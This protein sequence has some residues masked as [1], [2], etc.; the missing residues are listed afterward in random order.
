ML[1]FYKEDFVCD[2]CGPTPPYIIMDGKMTGPKQEL[3]K[4]I[5]ELDRHDQDQ[6]PLRQ[7]SFNEQRVFLHL[8][9]ERDLVK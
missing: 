7:G 1:Q 5:E 8:K 3:I 9:H 2:S 4:N 6:T